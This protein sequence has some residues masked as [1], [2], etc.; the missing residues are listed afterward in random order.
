MS[1]SHRRQKG[2][3]LVFSL[4]ILLVMTTLGVKAI[5]G[6]NLQ[7][8]LAA[9]QKQS[10]EAA[11]AAESGAAL[12]IEWLR[13]HPEAWG[14]AE[15][16]KSDPVLPSQASVAAKGNGGAVHWIERIDFQ[17][18]TATIVSRGGVWAGDEVLARRTVTAAL[19]DE[20]YHPDSASAAN[21]RA[22]TEAGSDENPPDRAH[23]STGGVTAVTGFLY[24]VVGSKPSAAGAGSEPVTAH[25]AV[26]RAGGVTTPDD[27]PRTGKIR[28]RVLFWR[29]SATAEES[30]PGEPP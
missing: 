6:S 8:R 17:G 13:T 5:L 28:G 11:L 19:R 29:L 23:G 25:D 9:N 20:D 14:N 15:A 21:E 1:A 12:A 7:E 4:L 30:R 27:R 10:I 24:G 3:V 16:W 2:T 26:G 18:D 22:E